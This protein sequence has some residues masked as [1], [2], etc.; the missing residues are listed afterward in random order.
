MVG[1]A[2]VVVV[3]A[4]VVVV[5]GA[6]VVVVVGAAVV[7]VVGACCC[8]CCRAYCSRCCRSCSRRS[9]R[10][11]SCGCG[12]WQF[13]CPKENFVDTSSTIPFIAIATQRRYPV[14]SSCAVKHTKGWNP[15]G[16]TRVSIVAAFSSNNIHA[17]GKL[18]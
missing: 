13:I 3:G 2:V 12:R 18:Q 4:A 10:S 6:A 5:V 17:Y 11:C 8:R 15:C 14:L 9:C 1:A 7:V 16:H